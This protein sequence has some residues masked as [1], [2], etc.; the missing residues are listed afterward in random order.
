MR[1][2]DGP[3]P[4]PALR[5]A[6]PAKVNLALHVL[7]RR[8][9]GYH[10]LQSLVAFAAVTDGDEV[11]VR[12]SPPD[13][14]RS[15]DRPPRTP[16]FVVGGPF[17]GSVP[18]GAENLAVA[19]ARLCPEIAA[20]HLTKGLP[21][22]AG[23]G[24]GSA[25]AAAVLRA[26]AI[27]RGIAASDFAADG[28][29]L[30]ADIPVCLDGRP[31]IMEGIGEV[32]RP[33]ELPPVAGILVNPGVPLA[34][35]DVFRALRKRDNPPFEMPPLADA[36]ALCDWL[37]GTRNDLEAPARACCPDIDA[38]LNAVAATEGCALARMSGSGPTVFGLFPD[39]AARD[40]AVARLAS[41]APSRWWIRAVRFS[42]SADGL[43]PAVEMDDGALAPAG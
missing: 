20:V 41:A 33:A 38:V 37:A 24:G 31:S 14:E 30:G 13:R 42:G 27:H 3:P 23:I 6:V 2:T 15:D 9:S 29:S 26:A 43:P 40:A 12:F 25:D 5:L 16:D 7:G 11:T 21:V 32:L 17:A 22:A 39:A 28:L 1:A 10:E 35:A 4:P 19:A 34:T 36:G 18:H 8:E